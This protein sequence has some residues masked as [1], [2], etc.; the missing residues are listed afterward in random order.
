VKIDP[1]ARR[2]SL[3]VR[4]YK[5]A[6]EAEETSKFMDTQSHGEGFLKLGEILGKMINRE[7]NK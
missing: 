5:R 4:E 2:I 3:S 1:A 7:N 6:K